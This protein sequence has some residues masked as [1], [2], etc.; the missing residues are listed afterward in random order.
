MTKP[1]RQECECENLFTCGVCCRNAPPYLFTPSSVVVR[2]MTKPARLPNLVYVRVDAFF[3]ESPEAALDYGQQYVE[4][5]TDYVA[6]PV[7]VF[8]LPEGDDYQRWAVEVAATDNPT[9]RLG[10]LA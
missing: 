3:F 7:P 6:R 2:V 8:T 10:Y 4:R 9:V 1:R 5:F